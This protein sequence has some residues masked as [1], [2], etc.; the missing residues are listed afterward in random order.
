MVMKR[1]TAMARN[2]P[3]KTSTRA[4]HA[5][6]EQILGHHFQ[7][8][9]LLTLALTHRS[10][11]FDAGPHRDENLADPSR[12]NEQL[13]FL[14]DAALGLLVADAL[15]QRFPNSREGE[16]TRL[17]ASVVSRK[18]LGAVGERLGLGRWLRLGPTMDENGGRENRALLSNLV[19]ALIAALYLDG[20]LQAA[21]QFVQ[22]E[23]LQAALLG[24]EHSLATGHADLD[25]KT[26]LQELL[27]AEGRPRPEYRV[28][29]QSGPDHRRLFRVAVGFEGGPA[30]AEA[31]GS[32]K[33]EAQQ[34]AARGAL[35]HLRLQPGSVPA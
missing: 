26:A 4:T 1:V 25:P 31:E 23:V 5:A 22:R 28:V 17:R 19:E 27:Q 16:L 15:Y 33:K 10:F 13:E 29:A 3:A 30:L 12:D 2:V 21:Q 7:R 24:M 18:H 32:S 34:E 14:G 6:L 35:A 11:V 20:G 8:P 9:V